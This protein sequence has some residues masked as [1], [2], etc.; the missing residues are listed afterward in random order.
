LKSNKNINQKSTFEQGG[1]F[2]QYYGKKLEISA[3]IIDTLSPLEIFWDDIKI[4]QPLHDY[5]IDISLFKNRYE[6]LTS[7]W[8]KQKQLMEDAAYE[9]NV[10]SAINNSVEKII[11]WYITSDNYSKVY[12]RKRMPERVIK[13]LSYDSNRKAMLESIAQ[14]ILKTEQILSETSSIVNAIW[15]NPI[16]WNVN[17]DTNDIL[18]RIKEE[19]IINAN[20]IF[21][22]ICEDWLLWEFNNSNFQS[23]THNFIKLNKEDVWPLLNYFIDML[24]Q[25]IEHNNKKLYFYFIKRNLILAKN[26]EYIWLS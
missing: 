3:D 20:T 2:K 16:W 9:D 8:T 13:V 10:L 7:F 25:A 21:E 1:I 23:N 24:L 18:P 15:E 26:P 14:V 12:K 11:V 19:L 6:L 22:I 4:M 17:I 5:E